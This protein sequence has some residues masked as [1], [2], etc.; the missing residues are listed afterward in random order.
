MHPQMLSVF[1]DL[2]QVV[3]ELCAS[4]SLEGTEAGEASEGTAAM[5]AVV[6]K[7]L[8]D[9]ME[10]QGLNIRMLAEQISELKGTMALMTTE[11]VN[12]KTEVQELQAKWNT[13]I[14]EE[15]AA[16]NEYGKYFE[17]Q[18][19]LKQELRADRDRLLEKEHR[20]AGHLGPTRSEID[21]FNEYSDRAYFDAM[22]RE[23][24]AQEAM[25]ENE[26][27]YYTQSFEYISEE[28]AGPQ[29]QEEEEGERYQEPEKKQ[30]ETQEEYDAKRKELLAKA[31]ADIA[32]KAAKSAEQER[33]LKTPIDKSHEW[34]FYTDN[35][36]NVWKQNYKTGE[37]IWWSYDYGKRQAKATDHA[38]PSSHVTRKTPSTESAWEKWRKKSAGR[39]R[40]RRQQKRRRKEK[41]GN[42]SGTVSTTFGTTLI[43]NRDSGTDRKAKTLKEN[44][45]ASP[46]KA[47]G[48]R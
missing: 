31:R 4:H 37:K 26:N 39:E 29:W 32:A 2:G 42:G 23:Q 24:E 21:E 3:Q 13:F 17:E 10:K 12:L 33:G 18:E 28:E 36:G 34:K 38:N 1:K 16:R 15:E 6:A 44:R 20:M 30:E 27:E 41:S 40:R 8:K 35:Q 25:E 5:S 11:V 22:T 19:K 45:F 46:R 9:L 7:E 43:W 47:D 14:E 48:T